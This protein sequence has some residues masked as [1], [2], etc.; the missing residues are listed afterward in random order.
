ML[1]PQPNNVNNFLPSTI[2][3][4]ELLPH[5]LA[6]PPHP[7]PQTL[8]SDSSYDEGIKAQISAV[9]KIPD[10]NLLEETSGGES[11]LNVSAPQA[12]P[13]PFKLG[14]T[15]RKARMILPL[16]AQ[17]FLNDQESR[18]SKLTCSRLNPGHQSRPKYRSLHLH[19]HCTHQCIQQARRQGHQVGGALGE[20]LWLLGDLRC[21]TN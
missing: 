21:Q 4:D 2:N 16:A 18:S 6:F 1:F 3:M 10:K 5:L 11:P 17:M 7:A 13:S 19:P 8:L 14:R 20:D 9:R 15:T 12:L